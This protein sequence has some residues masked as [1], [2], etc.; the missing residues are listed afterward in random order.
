MKVKEKKEGKEKIRK[1]ERNDA[2]RNRLVT[3]RFSVE[4]TTPR[5][6]TIEREKKRKKK[7][8]KKRKEKRKEKKT[9]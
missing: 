3:V 6:E 7:K 1:K 2:R 5:M 9:S 4:R 8:G